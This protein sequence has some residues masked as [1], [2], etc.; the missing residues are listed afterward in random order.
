MAAYKKTDISQSI[1]IIIKSLDPVYLLNL[2]TI[3]GSEHK[4]ISHFIEYF[5]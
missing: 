1:E 3:H 5:R 4:K 2:F